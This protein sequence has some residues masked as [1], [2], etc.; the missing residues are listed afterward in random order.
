MCGLKAETD[1]TAEIEHG[2]TWLTWKLISIPSHQTLVE[3]VKWIYFGWIMKGIARTQ[4]PTNK[5][6]APESPTFGVIA[7]VSPTGVQWK[8]LDLGEPP[9]GSRYPLC[10]VSMPSW[11]PLG[12]LYVSVCRKWQHFAALLIKSKCNCLVHIQY[13]WEHQA[14]T[15]HNQPTLCLLWLQCC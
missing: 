13:R 8:G 9:H 7:G 1:S 15:L 5:N 14:S 12:I 6:C 4:S 2:L 11:V 10:Q 3:A